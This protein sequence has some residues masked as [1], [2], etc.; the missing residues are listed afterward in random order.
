[1]RMQPAKKI[2]AADIKVAL[3]TYYKPPAHKIFFEVSNDTGAKARRWVDAVALGVWPSTGHEIIGVEIK[4]SRSDFRAE[5]DNPRKAQE[6]MRFCTRWFLAAPARMV[7]PDEL[8][9]TWGLL[10][11]AG[12]SLKRKV[13]APLLEP[14][15]ITPGFMMAVLRQANS[16][17][18]ALVRKLVSERV[19]EAGEHIDRAIESGIAARTTDVSYRNEQMEKFRDDLRA[20]TGA[21]FDDWH[22]DKEALAAAYLLLRETG[23]HRQQAW[24]FSDL[25][26]A[27][28]GMR[29]LAAKL[30]VVC[31]DERFAVI[32]RRL[33]EHRAGG[34]KRRK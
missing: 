30:D 9:R 6:I 5:L 34:R 13:S 31:G 29:D 23:L 7:S 28:K 1:M 8:P 10:E 27:A 25:L 2:A 4:V 32:R 11:Y 15:P 18:D 19:G 26:G 12:G 16:V 20:I 3:L 24:S 21:D 17:D 14:E 33:E 22:T